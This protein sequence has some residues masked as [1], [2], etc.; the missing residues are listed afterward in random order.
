M[1]IQT[2]DKRDV[3]NILYCNPTTGEKKST[4]PFPL[5]LLSVEREGKKLPREGNLQ[6]F[7]NIKGTIYCLLK[8]H[9][10]SYP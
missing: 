1:S 10:F 4:F 6:H 3:L 7:D 5:H 9:Q 8:K 2:L